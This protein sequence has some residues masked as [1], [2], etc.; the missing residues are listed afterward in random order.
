MAAKEVR[1]TTQISN[2]RSDRTKVIQE[3]HDNDV[4][5]YHHR[6]ADIIKNAANDSTYAV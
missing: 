4:Q 5:D 3:H 1:A 6:W 2:E